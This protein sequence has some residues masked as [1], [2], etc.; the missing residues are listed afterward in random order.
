M[1]NK[2]TISLFI[3]WLSVLSIILGYLTW[4][5][6]QGEQSYEELNVQRI[7]INEA[8]GQPRI[9]LSN[10]EKLPGIFMDGIEYPHPTRSFGGIIFFNSEGDEVGGLVFD[11]VEDS[12]GHNAFA[13]LAFDKY[14]QDQTVTI[15]YEDRNGKRKAG[16]RI[17]DQPD[18]PLV[19]LIKLNA[20]IANTKSKEEADLIRGEIRTLVEE[21]GSHTERVFVGTVG[22]ESSLLRLSDKEG[23]T[24]II[25]KV[26]SLGTSSLVFY[27]GNGNEI[28]KLP[29][30]N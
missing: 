16:L 17:D 8:D 22:D 14:K 27:D 2:G 23:R 21:Q 11:A 1:T 6:F 19:P 20:K 10:K 12:K 24:R 28:M 5:S 29:A 15:T 13:H 3:V 25:M 26:D 9:I 18:G 30:S 4:N 7:N